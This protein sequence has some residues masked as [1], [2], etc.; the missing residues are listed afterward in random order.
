[1][2]DGNASHELVCIDVDHVDHGDTGARDLPDASID[3]AVLLVDDDLVR[4]LTQQDLLDLLQRPCIEDVNGLVLFVR[5]VVVEAV[6]V[7]REVV[8]VGAAPDQSGHAACGRVDQMMDVAGVVTLEDSDG[9]TLVRIES[10]DPLSGGLPC[11]Q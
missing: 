8:C 5:A 11:Q 7:H 3:L 6:R 1:M 9:D 10:R 4:P 2:V